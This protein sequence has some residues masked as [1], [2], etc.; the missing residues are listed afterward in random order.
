MK[1]AIKKQCQL[2]IYIPYSYL[3]LYQRGYKGKMLDTKSERRTKGINDL[4]GF[5]RIHINN[6]RVD[7]A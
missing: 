2:S 1:S 7:L 3:L 6:I 5:N 4:F